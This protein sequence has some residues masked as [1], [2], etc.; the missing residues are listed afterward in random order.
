MGRFV[1]LHCILEMLFRPIMGTKRLSNRL[2]NR[3]SN[4]LT[5]MDKYGK[6]V[7]LMILVTIYI[8]N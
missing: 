6:D 7:L 3:L 8:N 1:P 4:G 5:L 2:I